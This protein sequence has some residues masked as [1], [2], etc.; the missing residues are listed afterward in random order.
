MSLR[1]TRLVL[2]G[3]AVWIVSAACLGQV[4][5]EGPTT[6]PAYCVVDTGQTHCFSDTGQ[7]RSV[8]RPGAPFHGQD[9]FYRGPQP[10][11][12]DNGD[13]TVSDLNTGLMWQKTPNLGR[14]ATYREAV[15]RAGTFGLAGYTDWRLPTIKE[16]YSLID[17][18][19]N[20]RAQ[21]PI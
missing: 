16:L 14:K 10:R 12:R 6:G 1:L 11:Y 20:C 2:P 8:P 15:A 7:L 4:A 17:F 9:A 3:V 5:G 18:N 21:P 19:G 13:G